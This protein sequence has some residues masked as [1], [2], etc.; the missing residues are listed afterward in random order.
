MTHM[1]YFIG[2][3]PDAQRLWRFDPLDRVPVGISKRHS[4]IHSGILYRCLATKFNMG[5]GATLILAARTPPGDKKAHLYLDFGTLVG[6]KVDILEDCDWTQGTGSLVPCFNHNR[7][8]LSPSSILQENQGQVPFQASG[9]LIQDPTIIDVGTVIPYDHL[10][11]LKNRIG[12]DW[13]LAIDEMILEA[14]MNY[15]IR[16]TSDDTSNS[17]KLLLKWY[18]QEQ[19]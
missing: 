13:E 8:A 6:A 3:D 19:E 7:A 15:A 10:F 5:N 12:G 16:L 11:G 18:E 1:R 2:Q 4:A 17:N 9:N 14:D